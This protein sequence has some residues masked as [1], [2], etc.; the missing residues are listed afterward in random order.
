MLVIGV[1]VG[2]VLAVVSVPVGAIASR[3]HQTAQGGF[4]AADW[5]GDIDRADHVELIARHDWAGQRMW[6]T[7]WAPKPL[8]PAWSQSLSG[9]IAPADDPRPAFAG[10]PYAG[11]EQGV[12]AFSYGWPFFGGT[13]RTVTQ[14]PPSAP[15]SLQN[16]H[17]VEVP[18][19]ST[20]VR[21]PLRPIWPGLLANTAFYAALT[22]ALLAAR[23]WW[24]AKR[25]PGKGQCVACGYEL[26][27]GVTVC[28]ECGL[29]LRA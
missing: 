10:R 18:F 26:G 12:Y 8:D 3:V 7:H 29:A 1:V 4:P 9:W 11:H 14:R 27:E 28:P 23:R 20:F 24:R 19:R 15:P 13:G 6:S 21:F 2:V 16:E 5:Q 22:L 25:R 17:L